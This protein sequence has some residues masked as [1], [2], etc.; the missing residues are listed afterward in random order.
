LPPAATLT[1]LADSLV[2]SIPAGDDALRERWFDEM[3]A[4]A[5]NTFVAVS[6]TPV[7]AS[8]VCIAPTGTEATNLTRELGAFFSTASQMRLIAPWSPEANR[9]GFASW[10]RAREQWRAIGDEIGKA[11]S[12]P[13]VR[14]YS[15]KISAATRRGASGEA[16]RL[17]KEQAAKGKELQAKAQ[18]QLRAASANPMDPDLLDLYARLHAPDLTNFA[19]RKALL[20]ELA[21]KL[22]EVRY[23]GDRPAPGADAWSVT[24]GLVTQH[25]VLVEARWIGFCNPV[26]GLPAMADWLDNRGC[27]QIK[28]EL[29]GGGWSGGLDEADE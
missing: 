16:T 22:G 7:T 24:A 14:S 5:T 27:R 19:A 23:A 15:A 21:A 3:Q 6:N 12:D 9:S 10:R 13:A 2:L 1:R 8:L 26:C 11:W 18:A 17:M 28:Y 20:R 29:R 25:G 4:S